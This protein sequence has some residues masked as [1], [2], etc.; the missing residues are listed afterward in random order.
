MYIIA[1]VGILRSIICVAIHFLAIRSLWRTSYHSN[2]HN[3]NNGNN[4]K[5]KQVLILLNICVCE[6]LVAVTLVPYWISIVLNVESYHFV[7]VTMTLNHATAVSVTMMMILLTVDR[8]IACYTPLKYRT[9]VTYNMVK[10]SLVICWLV[11]VISFVISG[12]VR[13]FGVSL[14]FSSYRI[15][16]NS[17]LLA[18]YVSSFA[19][20]TTTYCYMYVSVVNMQANNRRRKWESYV[21]EYHC[22]TGSVNWHVRRRLSL[23]TYSKNNLRRVKRLA[24]L[25]MFITLTFV[26][27]S[28]I[29]AVTAGFINYRHALRGDVSFRRQL[30]NCAWQISFFT[31]PMVYVFGARQPRAIYRKLKNCI[32]W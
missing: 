7:T 21:I 15:Y 19:C 30:L 25:G 12:V 18:F 10:V 23:F 4:N 16:E 9:L 31:A 17:I 20:S 1:V 26:L 13:L 32:C 5:N 6:T 2:I 14:L 28:L 29:P 3:N 8:F 22:S 11:G 27:F 24:V